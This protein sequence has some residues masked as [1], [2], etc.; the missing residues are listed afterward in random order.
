MS[1]STLLPKLSSSHSYPPGCETHG[2]FRSQTHVHTNPI[3]TNLIQLAIGLLGDL[4]LKRAPLRQAPSL[5]I[6]HYIREYGKAAPAKRTNEERRVAIGVF[7]LSSVYGYNR[8][9][10]GK[11]MLTYQQVIFSFPEN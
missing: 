7:F 11:P 10:Y 3:V 4:G 9:M 2:S 6:N 8:R 5:I 1:P